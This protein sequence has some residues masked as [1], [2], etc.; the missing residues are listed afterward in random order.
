MNVLKKHDANANLSDYITQIE[1]IL[2]IVT[3]E[4]KPIAVLMPID[5]IDLETLSHF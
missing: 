2:V 1:D 4:E 3:A 5:N